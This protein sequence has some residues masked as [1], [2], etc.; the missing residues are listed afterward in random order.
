ME[1]RE[2][3]MYVF[4]YILF[5]EIVFSVIVSTICHVLIDFGSLSAKF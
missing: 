3:C 1:K 5:Y 2:A 4:F